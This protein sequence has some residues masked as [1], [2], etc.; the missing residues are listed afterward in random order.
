MLVLVHLSNWAPLPEL[1]RFALV[2]SVQ[3]FSGELILG[4][5]V[6]LIVMSLGRWKSLLW[7]ISGQ[8]KGGDGVVYHWLRTVAYNC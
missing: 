1:W 7:S 8:A 3:F 2:K 6:C 4:F 5:L